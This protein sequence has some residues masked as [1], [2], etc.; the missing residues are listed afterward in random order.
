MPMAKDPVGGGLE[1]DGS[2]SGKYCSLCYDGGQFRHPEFTVEQMQSHCVEQLRNKG[3]PAF[4][5]WIF[6][7]SLPRLERWRT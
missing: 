5:G 6:T 3:M 4:F 7:R 2:K 1:S